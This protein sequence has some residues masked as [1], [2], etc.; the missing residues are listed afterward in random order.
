MSIEAR[1]GRQHNN[2]SKFLFL[3]NSFD[4]ASANCFY[5]AVMLGDEE[6]I[7]D[8]DKFP[9]FLDELKV[10]IPD[11]MLRLVSF[12][13][14]RPHRGAPQDLMLLYTF[15]LRPILLIIHTFG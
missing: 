12:Q 4:K 10:G 3:L 9:C 2:N 13:A 11:R 5:N 15:L 6:L 7:L 8:I 1:E 14:K